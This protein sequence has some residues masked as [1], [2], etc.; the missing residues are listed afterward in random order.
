[1]SIYPPTRQPTH[2]L[3]GIGDMSDGSG[4]INPA[5]LNASG[6][7]YFIGF[8]HPTTCEALRLLC[9]STSDS[10]LQRVHHGIAWSTP[11]SMSLSRASADQVY[12]T[13][14]LIQSSTESGPRGIKR[15]RSP[16]QYGEYHQGDDDGKCFAGLEVP[17]N[18]PWGAA[19]LCS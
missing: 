2:I 5:A 10:L 16:E 13:G 19:D 12:E 15:S 8:L 18:S 1:M 14:G 3:N 17:R 11:I 7:L 6:M 4:T 9:R